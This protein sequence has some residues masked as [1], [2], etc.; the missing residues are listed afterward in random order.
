MRTHTHSGCLKLILAVEHRQCHIR[1][2]L[3][4]SFSHSAHDVKHF[5]WM[6]GMHHESGL[7]HTNRHRRI[8]P[9]RFRVFRWVSV[10]SGGKPGKLKGSCRFVLTCPTGLTDTLRSPCARSFLGFT[11]SF[12][13]GRLLVSMSVVAFTSL[14]WAPSG[15]RR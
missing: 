14:G 15:N 13:V 11:R 9:A 2:K 10:V 8:F 6:N 3:D 7:E 1:R 12:A 4:H 5:G